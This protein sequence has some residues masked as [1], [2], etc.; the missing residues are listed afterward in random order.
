MNW[1]IIWW[2]TNELNDCLINRLMNWLIID[3]QTNE[4]IDWL[5]NRLMK[6]LITKFCLRVDTSVTYPRNEV[7]PGVVYKNCESLLKSLL[8]ISRSTP[9]YRLSRRQ[10]AGDYTV[11]CQLCLGEPRLS[12][13]D[14]FKVWQRRVV[15]NLTTLKGLV[16]ILKCLWNSF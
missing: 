2:K 11:T 9:G 15:V 16:A 14:Q 8:T 1:L 6:W 5:I 10:C 4:L 13:A 3:K 7:T 12:S